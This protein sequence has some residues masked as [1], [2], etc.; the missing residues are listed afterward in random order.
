MNRNWISSMCT[1]N[2]SLFALCHRDRIALNLIVSRSFSVMSFCR[3]Y[4]TNEVARYASNRLSDDRHWCCICIW[5][6]KIVIRVFEHPWDCIMTVYFRMSEIS[7]MCVSWAVYMSHFWNETVMLELFCAQ[8]SAAL[9][10]TQAI[11]WDQT[12]DE[13]YFFVSRILLKTIRS[14]PKIHTPNRIAI[15]WRIVY[16]SRELSCSMGIDDH[17]DMTLQ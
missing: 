8:K 4:L 14:D 5:Y 7:N 12:W 16:T 17:I 11:R 2:P 13:F 6:R 3:F 9:L 15:D 10:H 1:Q